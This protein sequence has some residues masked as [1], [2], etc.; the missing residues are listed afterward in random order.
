MIAIAEKLWKKISK[1]DDRDLGQQKKQL[2][3]QQTRI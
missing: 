3:T 1:D 2:L